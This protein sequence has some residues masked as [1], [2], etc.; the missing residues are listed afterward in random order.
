MLHK[1]KFS[2]GFLPKNSL[3]I[4]LK[5]KYHEEV[6]VDKLNKSYNA[7]VESCFRF[8]TAQTHR[9]DYIIKIISKFVFI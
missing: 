2:K 8:F 3:K 9:I 7:V 4:A 1:L 5:R 6:L